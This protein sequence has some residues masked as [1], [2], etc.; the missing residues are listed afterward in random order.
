[1]EK[2]AKL[3]KL[4]CERKLNEGIVSTGKRKYTLDYI[5]KYLYQIDEKD[6]IQI[7]I[8]LNEMLRSEFKELKKFKYKSS[9]QLVKEAEIKYYIQQ[10]EIEMK[11]ILNE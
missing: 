8:E 7:L 9:A 4:A 1:M 2:N 11:K 3:F 10:F 6:R 5:K